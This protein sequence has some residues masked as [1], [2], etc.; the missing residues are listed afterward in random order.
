[1]RLVP[2][3][4]AVLFGGCTQM[5]SRTAAPTVLPDSGDPVADAVY[6]SLA[7]DISA[8]RGDLDGAFSHYLWVAQKTRSV[9]AAEKAARIGMH[10]GKNGRTEEA[11]ELWALLAPADT[12]ALEIKAALAIREGRADEAYNALRAIIDHARQAGNGKGFISVAGVVSGS[13]NPALGRALMARLARDFSNDPEARYANALV[14]SAMGALDEAAKEARA[15]VT[16]RPNKEL[17]WLLLSRIRLQQNRDAES[18]AVL[19]E[20]V[21]RNPS[22]RV[23]RVAY[24]RWLVEGNRLDLAYAEFQRL[25]RDTPDDPDVLFSVGALATQLQ[26]WDDA[27]RYWKRMLELGERSDEAHY[28]L[29]EVEYANGNPEGAIEFYQQVGRG[30]LR[31]EAAM[32]RAEVHAEL[33]DLAAARRVFVEQR[34][35]FAER[36]ESLYLV[37]A[38]LLRNHNRHAEAM[39]VYD[40]AL[41]SFPGDP[42]LLYAR[43]MHAGRQN[44]LDILERD[45]RAIIA[46]DPNHSDALNALGYT[47][48]DQT[49][50]YEEALALIS[51]ALELDPENAAIL[52]SMGW[53]QYRLGNLD[54]AIAYLERAAS[55]DTDS[56]IAAHLGEVLWVAGRRE[57]ALSVWKDALE[58]DSKSPHLREVLQRLRPME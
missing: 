50:R 15:A 28:F 25:L 55:K 17:A 47:L 42:D 52:D 38:N 46:S 34:V 37:E 33:G 36:A 51:R 10:L 41:Q 57:E 22:S 26:H 5:P 12:G 44:R 19:K 2:I 32:R 45:L 21:A 56:E 43:A 35:L 20:S 7:A 29:A 18:G 11:A 53:V 54:S 8:H 40:V 16:L 9:E 1:M 30:P 13:D 49:D 48:A 31:M 4:V 3:V 27:R 58:R 14:L 23:L 39:A 6:H 24:A